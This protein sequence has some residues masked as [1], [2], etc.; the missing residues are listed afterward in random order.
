[1]GVIVRDVARRAAQRRR[2]DDRPWTLDLP[3]DIERADLSGGSLSPEHR[4]ATVRLD[5][6]LRRACDAGLE[7]GGLLMERS[8]GPERGGRSQ[9]WPSPTGRSRER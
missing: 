6:D 1:M 5:A 7:L 2:D 8:V 4:I 3:A 9:R